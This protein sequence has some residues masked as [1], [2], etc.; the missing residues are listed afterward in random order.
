MNS[1]QICNEHICLKISVC[2]GAT[3]SSPPIPS[4]PPPNYTRGPS[5][6]LIALNSPVSG[7]MRGIRGADYECHRQ[8]RRS[9]MRGTYRAFLSTSTQNLD[10]IIY[11][12]KDRQIPIVN[13][14]GQ[15]LFKSWE[16]L[17]SGAGGYFNHNIPIYSFNGRDIMS[18]TLWPQK[19][20]WHGSSKKGSKVDRQACGE[21]HKRNGD[22]IG[23]GSSLTRHMLLDQEPYSCNNSFIVLCIQNTA[24]RNL[25][26]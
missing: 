4:I 3:T 13:K 11:Y 19:I 25:R 2:V 24:R 10:S 21:W 26:H 22:S 8:A 18:D 15:M 6:H 9:S 5:L 1:K 17:V 23:L 20:V 14:E 16:D 7:R 12:A